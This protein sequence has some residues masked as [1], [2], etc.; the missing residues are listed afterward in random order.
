MIFRHFFFFIPLLQMRSWV[1][2]PRSLFFHCSNFCLES[3][4]GFFSVVLQFRNFHRCT[5]FLIRIEESF[6]F[7]IQVFLQL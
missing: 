1:L 6:Q 2:M 7:A 4:E 3:L 5:S